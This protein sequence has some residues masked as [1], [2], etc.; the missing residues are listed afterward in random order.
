[1]IKNPAS[2]TG[3]AFGSGQ[4]VSWVDETAQV[5]RGAGSS[6]ARIRRDGSRRSG[7][8]AKA[9][10]PVKRMSVRQYR[11]VMIRRRSD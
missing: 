7:R 10:R 11:M 8:P 9:V 4:M 5:A 6:R 1:M 3:I 2:E